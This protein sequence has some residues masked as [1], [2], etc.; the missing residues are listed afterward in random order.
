MVA[1]AHRPRWRSKDV[2][3][4]MARSQLAADHA[5][6]TRQQGRVAHDQ[7]RARAADPVAARDYLLRTSMI[8]SLREVT[9]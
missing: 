6:P 7:L 8:D 4:A 9:R 3:Q 2:V 1:E 5:R